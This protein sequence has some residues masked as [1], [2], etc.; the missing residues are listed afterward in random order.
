VTYNILRDGPKNSC[1]ACMQ[2]QGSTL[3]TISSIGYPLVL[4]PV[5]CYPVAKRLQNYSVPNMSF[6]NS[7]PVLNFTREMLR[8]IRGQLWAMTAAQAIL[9]MGMTYYEQ[10]NYYSVI[11]PKL[12]KMK[13]EYSPRFPY[14][15]DTNPPDE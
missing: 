3:Q 12:D 7:Y 5:I 10:T 1:A 6:K 15:E 8:P 4:V 9:G 14:P 13:T 2:I 11:K